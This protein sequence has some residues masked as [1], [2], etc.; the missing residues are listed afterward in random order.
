MAWAREGRLRFRRLFKFLQGLGPFAAAAFLFAGRT[1]SANQQRAE[2]NLPPVVPLTAEQDH[3]RTMELL[4]ISSLR[5][6]PDGDPKSPNAAN[7]DESK[8]APHGKLP[9]PLV[10][11]DGTKV[12]T[13]EQWWQKRRPEIVEGFDREIYGRVPKNVPKVNWEVISTI[14]EKNG[15]VP[16]VTK[17]VVG[18]VDNTSYPLISVDIQLTVSTP[19]GAA[20]PVPVMM[21]FGL[22]AEALAAIRKRLTE[23]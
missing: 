8:V 18:H 3:Q 13:A 23:A 7:F 5:R 10:F 14:N 22:S 11:N 2:D 16:A 9:D 6:G 21:E 17:K 19:A 1:D 4:H 15:D 12:I 20:G